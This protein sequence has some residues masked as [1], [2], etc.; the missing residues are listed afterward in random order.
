[1]LR[2]VRPDSPHL[3]LSARTL[4]EEYAAS[5]NLDLGFQGFAHEVESLP[6]EYGPPS[7]CFLLAF[8]DAAPR[9]CG[10]FRRLSASD[11][12]MKRLYVVPAGR[13]GRVGFAI[14]SAL[15][16]EARRLGYARMVLDTLPTMAPAQ[17]LYASLGFTPTA[18]YRYNPVAGTSFLE[19]L[20]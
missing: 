1:M 4:V 2:L 16:E 8:D 14:A 3:W 13:G 5:L 18:P 17:T 15:V 10:A 9:G 6:I 19:L 20:L 11:C 12:E 7:G